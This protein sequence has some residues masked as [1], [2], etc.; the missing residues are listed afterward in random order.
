MGGTVLLTWE[1]W[2]N[3]DVVGVRSHYRGERGN[4]LVLLEF[5][6]SWTKKAV[7]IY[8]EVIQISAREKCHK[9]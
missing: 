6:F 7:N 9:Y 4:L 2:P 5:A 8:K 1:V 3:L